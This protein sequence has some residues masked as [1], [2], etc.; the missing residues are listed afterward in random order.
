M[1]PGESERLTAK[2]KRC[3]RMGA[4]MKRG[5]GGVM[6]KVYSKEGCGAEVPFFS[7]GT[8]AGHRK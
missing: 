6:C 4:P 5:C 1:R 3:F 8:K 7:L 2:A